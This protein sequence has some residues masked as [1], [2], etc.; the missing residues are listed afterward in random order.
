MHSERQKMLLS[1]P[2]LASDPELVALRM[3][4]RRLTR[5]FNQTTEEETIRRR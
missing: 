5:L 4:A 3:R 2:Y 1:E